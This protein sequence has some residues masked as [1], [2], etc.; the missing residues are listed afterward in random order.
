MTTGRNDLVA[1]L[2]AAG[3]PLAARVL[4][5]QMN[6]RIA[7][8]E[9]TQ[10]ALRARYGIVASTPIR[11]Y[12]D[13][14]RAAVRAF[15][16]AHPGTRLAT[17]SGSTGTPK[18]IAYPAERLRLYRRDSSSIAIRAYA[19]LGV[20][21]PGMFIF[22]SEKHDDSFAAFVLHGRSS[23][24]PWLAGLVEPARYLGHPALRPF[25]ASH[26]LTAAR[27]WLMAVADPGMLYATNPSTL[28]TFFTEVW[29]DWP[30]A[31]AIARLVV[32][33]DTSNDPAADGL[34]G[35]IDR[36]GAGDA[37][38]RLRML[39]SAS[40][41]L[42][43]E[44]WLPGLKGYVA[45]D[46]GYV[47]AFLH[48]LHRQL[49][50]ERFVHIPMYSM[51]TETIQ[52]LTVFDDDGVPHHLPLGPGVLYEFIP[53]GIDGPDLPEHLVAVSDLKVG[54]VYAM[55]VSDPWG[56]VRYQ[57]NDLFACVGHHRG[58]PD[59]RFLRRRGLAWSFTGEKLTGEQLSLAFAHVRQDFP[60]LG[61]GVEL[62]CFPT[63]PEGAVP[64]YCLVL[65]PTRPGT[66]DDADAMGGV[67]RTIG[68]AFDQFIGGLNQEFADK[69]H[70]GRLAPTSAIV[71]DHNALAIAVDRRTQSTADVDQRA[72]ESQFKLAPLMMM[73]WQDVER[74]LGAAATTTAPDS[75]P[76]GR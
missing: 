45:W 31:T 63:E 9:A 20:H 62:V 36:V 65:A 39:A 47:G 34:R 64:G 24:P 30:A 43:V 7:R 70:S 25:I 18:E 5:W 37:R 3:V 29:Q 66:V 8:F 26:G 11:G 42:P 51:S 10:S 72:W 2:M 15:A 57:T 1:R 68:R 50:P 16:A 14:T 38:G 71:V 61:N 60:V 23:V 22:A 48:E 6:R 32:D 28:S 41:P 46:G 54:G 44:Q 40:S 69:Q 58:L 76:Q 75:P 74:A 67:A 33:A 53:D 56:L 21:R 19:W 35:I 13:D 4:G 52:T 12:D 17:T 49:P 55:V 59:L 73:R 27:L